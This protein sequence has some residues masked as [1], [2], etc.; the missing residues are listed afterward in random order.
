MQLKTCHLTVLEFHGRKAVSTFD[1][2]LM[3]YSFMNFLEMME[4]LV[5]AGDWR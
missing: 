3:A 1:S 2:A 4:S 5:E